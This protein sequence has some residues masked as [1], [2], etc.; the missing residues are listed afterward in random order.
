MN[1][2]Y[3]TIMIT[4]HEHSALFLFCVLP[5]P[6]CY[7]EYKHSSGD[8]NYISH[9]LHYLPDVNSTHGCSKM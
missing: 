8:P 6:I 5:H 7:H 2:E 1:H 9:R 3:I 4:G